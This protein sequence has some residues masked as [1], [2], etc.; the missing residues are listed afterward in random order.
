M[1]GVLFVVYIPCKE[2]EYDLK[3][4]NK[5]TFNNEKGKVDESSPKPNISQQSLGIYQ[6]ADANNVIITKYKSTDCLHGVDTADAL[7]KSEINLNIEKEGDKGHMRTS[8]GGIKQVIHMKKK[9]LK[10]NKT[11]R[12]VDIRDAFHSST[13]LETVCIKLKTIIFKKIKDFLY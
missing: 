1:A 4:N 7:Y 3:R 12:A 5:T 6:H 11:A 10:I 8:W 2:H 9:K 13:P